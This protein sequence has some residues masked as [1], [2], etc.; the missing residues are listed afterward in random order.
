MGG[1]LSKLLSIIALVLVVYST[2]GAQH[3]QVTWNRSSKPV[4]VD[5]E[6]FHST[7]SVNLPTA[8]TLQ[9]GD[10]LF[11]ISHRFVPPI[12]DAKNAFFGLDGPVK[13]RLGLGYALANRMVLTLAR[14]NELDNVDLQLK[15]KTWQLRNR[16]A[17]VLVTLNAGAA[18]NTQVVGR[19]KSD[20]DNFQYYGQLILN[21]M[22]GKKLALGVVP[23][24]LYNSYIYCIDRQYSFTM[25][26]YVQY[27]VS[28]HWSILAEWNPTIT[29]FRNQHNSVAFGIELE[30]G[31]HFFKII[32][33]NNALLNPGQYLSGADINFKDADWRLGFNITR[34]LKLHKMIR[35]QDN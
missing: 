1:P 9:R 25:G 28:P 20:S 5:L 2:A 11:E 12:T 19:D 32:L 8:E 15:Y 14:S 31:G 7:H 13:M 6:L 26:N 29:G 24:Y 22:L 33:T 21:T 23:S 30:T 10:F 18:W 27:Y 16:I 3:R 34:L 17:P 4:A 35:R